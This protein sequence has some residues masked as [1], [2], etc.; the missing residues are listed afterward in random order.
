V[1]EFYLPFDS[2]LLPATAELYSHEM[3]G[4]QYTNLYQQARALGLA[5]RWNEVRRAYAE[6]NQALG[7]I[8]KVTPSSKA[9]G[10][11]ALFMVANGLSAKELAEG[12]RELAFPESVIDLVSGMMGQ[13][14][15]GWPK[16][17]QQRVLKGR[18]PIKGR[19]AASL[20]DADFDAAIEKVRGLIAREPTRRDALSSLL[21]PKVYEEY[22]AHARH[23]SDTSRLPTP[24]FFYGQETGEEITV[25]IEEG[26]TLIIKF[27]TISEPH[28]DGTRTVFFELNGQPRDVSVVDQSLEATAARAVQADPAN[29]KHVGASM[30]GMVVT[31]AVKPGDKITRGQK[32]FTLEAMKMETTMNSDV[33][34]R[35][36][37]VLVKPGS[38]VQAGD[39]LLR[40]E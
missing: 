11:L 10:D 1:R 3:P 22:T 28:A 14:P 25:A 4:G 20:P 19:A 6:A 23:Y 34:G 7:D 24:V 30:P 35:V 39:L 8:V 40:L 33:P 2:T 5:D 31:V 12:D 36:A 13:P 15:G 9:V 17:I 38:R 32:L 18:K 29:P 26:K 37:E 16:A 27:L 21:Y